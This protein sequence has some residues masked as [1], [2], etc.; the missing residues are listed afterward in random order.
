MV[1]KYV[2]KR[3]NNKVIIKM[4]NFYMSHTQVKKFNENKKPLGLL[5]IFPWLFHFDYNF[6]LF[7]YLFFCCTCKRFY[8]CNSSVPARFLRIALSPMKS[9]WMLLKINLKKHVSS[10]RKPTKNTMRC[11]YSLLSVYY[12]LWLI[13]YYH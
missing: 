5:I 12:F 9:V 8:Y 10:L 2:Y 4:H 13:L 7:N 3:T 11:L 1:L 6:N